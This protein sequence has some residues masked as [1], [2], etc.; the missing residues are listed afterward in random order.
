MYKKLIWNGVMIKTP[1]GMLYPQQV[2]TDKKIKLADLKNIVK[3]AYK[4]WKDAA[5]ENSNEDL[6][7]LEEDTPKTVDPKVEQ[8]RLAY[9]FVKDVFEIKQAEKSDL[10]AQA[11]KKA[12]NDKIA[13]LIA[14]KEEQALEN[15]SVEELKKLFKD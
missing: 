4:D 11:E 5:G 1:W 8:L 7:F 12:Y 6:A 9:E 10:K 3:A 2:A 15:L 14:K 13:A